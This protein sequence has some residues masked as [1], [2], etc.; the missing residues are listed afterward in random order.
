M[1]DERVGTEDEGEIGLFTKS[2]GVVSICSK[3]C[4]GDSLI[5]DLIWVSSFVEP[6]MKFVPADP[7][8]P[9]ESVGPIE[10]CTVLPGGP[11][12]PTGPGG[13]GIDAP[14]G[15]AGPCGPIEP[16]G[17]AGPIEPGPM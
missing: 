14:G 5:F 2:I 12:A 11:L 17:P 16:G 3:L 4:E 8:D 1:S 15:P 7:D 6:D 9:I 13:P 10:P